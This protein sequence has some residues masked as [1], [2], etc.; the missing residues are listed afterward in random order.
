MSEKPQFYVEIWC[1][2]EKGIDEPIC[3][4]HRLE[5]IYSDKEDIE[6]HTI[7]ILSNYADFCKKQGNRKP[8][9]GQIFN[10]QEYRQKIKGIE[11]TLL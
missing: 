10:E 6:K 11:Y 4:I 2:S 5:R 1:R 8:S 7:E 9:R 3:I